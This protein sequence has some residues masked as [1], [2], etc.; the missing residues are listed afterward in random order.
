MEPTDPL[1]E[2]LDA[3]VQNLSVM[4]VVMCRVYDA[5]MALVEIQ[6]P[7]TAANLDDWHRA[8]KFMGSYPLLGDEPFD[9]MPDEG[10]QQ[11]NDALRDD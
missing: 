7:A 10:E 2:Q 8:G 6:D 5:L 4:N 11:V 3:A 9:D 1:L